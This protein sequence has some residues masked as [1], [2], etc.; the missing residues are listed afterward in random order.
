MM[1]QR[2]GKKNLL[3]ISSK[4]EMDLSNVRDNFLTRVTKLIEIKS[5]NHTAF[6]KQK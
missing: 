4:S 5:Y 2:A 6:Y 1:P 3:G